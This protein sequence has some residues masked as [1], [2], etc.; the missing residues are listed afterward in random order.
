QPDETRIAQLFS[1]A[2]CWPG[3]RLPVGKSRQG[4][5]SLTS[6][7][8]RSTHELKMDADLTQKFAP[9]RNKR[10]QHIRG[11]NEEA[12][13][14]DALDWKNN[15]YDFYRL[16]QSILDRLD[17]QYREECGLRLC[18]L[19]GRYELLG[20]ARSDSAHYR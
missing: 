1:G 5:P 18:Q 8:S 9:R 2:K 13:W 10:H 6:A 17:L 20:L 3:M 11:F 16:F 14:A 4:Q 7:L 12:Q 15:D 19:A